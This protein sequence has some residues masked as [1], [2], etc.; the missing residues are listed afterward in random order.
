[1][2]IAAICA[3]PAS[4]NPGMVSVDLGLLHF[5]ARHRISGDVDLFNISQAVEF[6]GSGRLPAVRHRL[7]R[8]Q[9]ELEGYDVI[10]YWGD[11]LHTR[12]YMTHELGIM[13]EEDRG[14]PE[15]TF[16]RGLKLMLLEGA[17][18]SLLRKVIC[19]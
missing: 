18:E 12:R 8:D 6:P 14:K 10:L 13:I 3:F 2:K 17:P 5:V 1:M 9:S 15:E 19:F 4:N 16:N 11:F 7:L